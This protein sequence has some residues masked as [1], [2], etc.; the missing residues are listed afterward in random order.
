VILSSSEVIFFDVID[1]AIRE[2]GGKGSGSNGLT[3]KS[4]TSG[5]FNR[6]VRSCFVSRMRL[7]TVIGG[8]L[9]LG[10]NVSFSISRRMKKM[11]NSHVRA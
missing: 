9:E 1:A 7:N 5:E 6:D 2:I 10:S 4:E 3:K 11:K 8:K